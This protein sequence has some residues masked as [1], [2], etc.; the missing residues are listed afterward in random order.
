MAA[1]AKVNGRDERGRFANGNAGGHGRPPRPIE[2]QYV[3]VIGEVVGLDEWRRV[4]ER[5]LR[6]AENG[7]ATARAWLSKYVTGD[8]PQATLFG[9]AVDEHTGRD[10]DSDITHKAQRRA[11]VAEQTARH[12]ARERFYDSLTNIAKLIGNVQ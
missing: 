4:V 11:E 5:A 3:A 2:R 6:D 8:P 7:H 1:H 9:V 10:A 12:A